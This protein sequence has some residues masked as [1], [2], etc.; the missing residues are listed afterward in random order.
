[1]DDLPPLLACTGAGAHIPADQANP[2]DRMIAGVGDVQHVLVDRHAHGA[3]ESRITGLAVPEPRI[4]RAELAHDATFMRA[5]EHPVVRGVRD[6]QE[7]LGGH[8]LVRKTQWKARLT[9]AGTLRGVVDANILDH[10]LVQQL[11][12]PVVEFAASILA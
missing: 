5:F 3:I 6:V 11:L 4:A 12:D 2:A 10:G 7:T 9:A 8:H 1:M